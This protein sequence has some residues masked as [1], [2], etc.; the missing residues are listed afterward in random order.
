MLA[1]WVPKP[2]FLVSILPKFY[3]R[4]CL[5]KLA[6]LRVQLLLRRVRGVVAVREGLRL[7]V[8]PVLGCYIKGYLGAYFA[9]YWLW[10]QW[11]SKLET[12]FLISKRKIQ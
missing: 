12:E 8:D 3:P 1:F 2:W 7:C 10:I 11:D 5:L 9:Q 6:R 4:V